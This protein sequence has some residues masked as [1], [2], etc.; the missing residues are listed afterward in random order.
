M[1][2]YAFRNYDTFASSTAGKTREDE[3]HRIRLEFIQRLSGVGEWVPYLDVRFSWNFI[4]N[5][6]NL[7]AR[8]YTSNQFG[9]KACP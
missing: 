8:D 3:Q 7:D 9:M 6:S 1:Y 2:Q 5:S 4:K